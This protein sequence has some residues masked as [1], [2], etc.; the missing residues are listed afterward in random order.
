MKFQSN[1]D[2]FTATITSESA[3]EAKTLYNIFTNLGG[4]GQYDQ[5]LMTNVLRALHGKH[6]DDEVLK[7]IV[8]ACEQH[9]YSRIEGIKLISK[10]SGMGLKESKDYY[11]QNK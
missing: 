6:V 11:N 8:M 5:G 10:V 4:I 9:Y 1:S 7:T 3:E 2:D